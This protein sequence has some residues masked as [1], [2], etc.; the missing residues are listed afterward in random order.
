MIRVIAFHGNP[1]RPEDWSLI[2]SYAQNIEWIDAGDKFVV[3][4]P[5]QTI[6]IG[7][8]W[9]C[10]RILKLLPQFSVRKAILL[11]PYLVQERPLSGLAVFL[12]QNSL[13]KD[14]LIKGNHRKAWE[15][16]F[17]DLLWPETFQQRKEYI[18]VKKF[19]QD[20]ASWQMAVRNK[21][22]MQKNPWTPKDITKTPLKAFFGK[23]D[24]V[25]NFDLQSAVLKQ[26][27]RCEIQVI[28]KTGHSLIWSQAQQ[29]AEEIFR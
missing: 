28:E 19:L 8:S 26:Y 10:Y 6:F 29:M 21:I 7:H 20:T 17:N 9:G 11:T 12:L 5:A 15:S 24:K 23:E 1:G 3:E 25:S 18:D 14:F 22:A 16:F 4:D 13:V 27:P 2:R